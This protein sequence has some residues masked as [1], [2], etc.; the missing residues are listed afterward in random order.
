MNII[1]Y[2]THGTL[3]LNSTNL[4]FKLVVTLHPLSYNLPI[5]RY[6]CVLA[7]FLKKGVGISYHLTTGALRPLMKYHCLTYFYV[8]I[9]CC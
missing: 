5:A 9:Q 3:Y 7:M 1:M 2:R 4:R 6:I 8:E